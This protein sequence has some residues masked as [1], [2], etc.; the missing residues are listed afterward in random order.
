MRGGEKNRRGGRVGI[1]LL[2]C[3]LLLVLALLPANGSARR[4]GVQ[5]SITV[6]GDP[7]LPPDGVNWGG[8]PDA[9]EPPNYRDNFCP[10]NCTAE[11]RPG[12]LVDLRAR[13][14]PTVTSLT[15]SG[16]CTG[17]NP[18][19]TVSGQDDVQV[20]A[21]LRDRYPGNPRTI[22]ISKPPQVLRRAAMPASAVFRFRSNEPAYFGCK[23]NAGRWRA[24]DSPKTYRLHPGS[25]R[26]RV[27]AYDAYGNQD[28]TP[29]SW[30]FR[31]V[32]G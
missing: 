27:R 19:C 14:E 8:R 22:W 7:L 9:E 16:D 23:L 28:P 25:Y 18:T 32:K 29:L 13:F 26:V 21:T 6:V 1:A 20:T 12:W 5:V 2:A 30:S 11:F 15:W 4:A 31:V 3:G 24:C 10:S 17:S